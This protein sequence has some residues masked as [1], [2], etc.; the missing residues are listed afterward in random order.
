[1][2]S[3]A[4]RI[5]LNVPMRL[6]VIVWRNSSSGNG[7]F[8]PTTLAGVPMP[9]QFTTIRRACPRRAM[10]DSAAPTAAGSVTSAAAN[11]TVA[12]SRSATALPWEWGRSRMVTCAPAAASRSAVARPSPEAPPVTSAAVPSISMS[13]V[14][15]SRDA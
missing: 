4:S 6:T 2:S 9:A 8:L 1:M 11:E 14:S 5:T 3:A 13:L 12:P 15:F 10:P 7:P